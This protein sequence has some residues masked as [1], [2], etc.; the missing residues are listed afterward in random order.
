M[1]LTNMSLVLSEY[2]ENNKKATIGQGLNE[3]GI[4]YFVNFYEN[5]DY[6]YTIIYLDHS[7]KYVK[8]V[9]ENFTLGILD[10]PI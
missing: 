3:S 2:S 8:D 4:F 9:A 6:L 7:L 1:V 5:N 10:S